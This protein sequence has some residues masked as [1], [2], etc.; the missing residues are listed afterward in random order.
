[1]PFTRTVEAETVV[2]EPC[3]LGAMNLWLADDD[4]DVEA[5]FCVTRRVAATI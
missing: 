5:R 3:G 4:L 2:A 1:M